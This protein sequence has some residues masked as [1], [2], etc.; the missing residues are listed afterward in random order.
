[1]G[2][3]QDTAIVMHLASAH[4]AFTLRTAHVLRIPLTATS[5]RHSMPPHGVVLPDRALCLPTFCHLL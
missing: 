2:H 5:H 4:K 1:M 3:G